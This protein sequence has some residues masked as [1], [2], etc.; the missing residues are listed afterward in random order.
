MRG[1]VPA[2]RVSTKKAPRFFPSPGRPG[3]SRAVRPPGKE[4][5]HAPWKERHRGLRGH[6]CPARSGGRRGG[7]RQR[8][9]LD[10]GRRP[11]REAAQGAGDGSQGLCKRA[12]KID[13]RLDRALKRLKGQANVKGSVARLAKRV[14]RAKKADHTEVETFL[15]H[16]LTFRR[17]LVTTLEQR[18]KDLSK[19]QTWC[20]SRGEGSG[21]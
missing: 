14:E 20:A 11:E 3:S 21:T 9:G 1:T 16:K 18:Q 19:V 6:R 12:K 2:H 10:T 17:S 5:H 4:Q 13:K 15:N 7:E 8:P